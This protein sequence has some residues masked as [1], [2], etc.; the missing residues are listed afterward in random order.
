VECLEG[1]QKQTYKNFEIILVCDYQVAL[2]FPKLRQKFFGHYV[3]P[4]EKR[5]IGAKMAKGEILAFIDDDAYPSEGWLKNMVPHFKDPKIA[6]VGGPGVTPPNVSWQETASGW[7][8]AS[9]AGGG[10]YTYRFLSN[11]KQFVDDYPSMNLAVRK[12]DFDKVGGYDSNFWPGE[13]TKLCLD[14]THKLGK[15]IIY[16]PKVLVYHHRRPLLLPH[17]R[18]N[19][20]FGLHR[21]FFARIL[22]ET[23]LKLIYFLPS[24]LLLGLIFILTS[25]IT[26]VIARRY[27]DVAISLHQVRSLGLYS[28]ALYF[29]ILF[30]NSLWI[31]SVI[32][33]SEATRQSHSTKALPQAFLSI[34]II[35]ITH[36]WYG[37]R[38]LQG[39]LFTGKLL[40]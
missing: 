8:S 36:L 29:F 10:I 22:P 27:S 3:G 15:K 23:S 30:L 14:L 28:F 35:F 24:I 16:D 11:N 32:A 33:R 9:P 12:T 5:D 31:Y 20:N 40:R 7:A 17:L 19:G 26:L 39:F 1:I 18:Q 4:A 37:A 13:D 25:P 6:G 21:G 38:F 34:P 2:N